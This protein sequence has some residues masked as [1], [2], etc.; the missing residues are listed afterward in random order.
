M[1]NV[2]KYQPALLLAGRILLVAI[3]FLG[4]LSL[5]KGQ[6]P[7]DYAATKGVPAVLVWAGYAIKLFGG[8]GIIIGLFTRLSA[9]GLILFTLG[10]AFIFHPYPDSV[11]LKEISMIGGLLVLLATGPGS[12]SVDAR[13]GRK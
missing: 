3:Y 11:F 7:V 1:I 8:L 5:L 10:T 12:I 2:S 9:L 13:M 6:V 4:G